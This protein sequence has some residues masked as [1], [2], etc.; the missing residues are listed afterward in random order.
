MAESRR[1]KPAN[2]NDALT[3]LRKV[4]T[5]AFG[6]LARAK[7]VKDSAQGNYDAAVSDY[8]KA[9][10]AL[11]AALIGDTSTGSTAQTVNV[12]AGSDST[13]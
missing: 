11:N 8:N 12:T 10:A 9:S 1:R 2:P 6:N 5:K 4:Q 3:N 7:N 13:E